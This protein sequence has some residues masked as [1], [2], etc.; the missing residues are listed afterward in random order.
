MVSFFWQRGFYYNR[1]L[2]FFS[3]FTLYS[4]R[5]IRGLSSYFWFLFAVRCEGLPTQTFTLSEN[6][7]ALSYS[8]RGTSLLMLSNTERYLL[9]Y[10]LVR[11]FPVLLDA[12]HQLKLNII[13]FF[14]VRTYRGFALRFS[15]P[16]T[17]RTRG[18]TFLRRHMAK[19]PGVFYMKT[20][21]SRWF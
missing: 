20:N 3:E 9:N 13:F 14:F 11:L 1:R 6:Y 7:R 5:S 15:R 10:T 12:T 21:T 16:L 2:S 17:R 8:T 18:R 19:P 4:I